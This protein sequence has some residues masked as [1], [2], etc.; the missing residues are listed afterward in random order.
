MSEKRSGLRIL[1]VAS[2]L[3]VGGAER[4]L[5]LL[6]RMLADA[7]HDVRVLTFYSGGALE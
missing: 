4:Q 6:A 5:V 3:R 2:S 1:F 7:G